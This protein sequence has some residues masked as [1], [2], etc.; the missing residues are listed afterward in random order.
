[1]KSISPQLLAFLE[2]T[3]SYNRA[4]LFLI[5]L[6]NGQVISATNCQT[7]VVYGYPPITYYPTLFGAWERG[8]YKT[9]VAFKPKAQK[10]KLTVVAKDTVLFP[11]ASSSPMLALPLMNVIQAGMFDGAKVSVFTIYWAIGGLPSD[12][13]AM[14]ALITF[15]GQI[16]ASTKTTRSIAEFDVADM[17]Y[18]LDYD[19][20]PNIIQSGCRY[21]LGDHGCTLNLPLNFSMPNSAAAGSNAF[22]INLTAS[23]T[24]AAFWNSFMTMTQ[25]EII[26]TS[27]LNNGLRYY[28]KQQISNTQ[29]QLAVPLKFAINTGDKF[30]LQPGCDKTLNKCQFQF[31]NLIHF[32]GQPYVPNPEAAI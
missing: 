30:N 2:T 31:N 21:K 10:M 20:P 23:V 9:E 19:T 18:L 3:N 32:G 28:I 8:S 25:G 7:A 29:I 16:A 4:D 13:V 6:I 11:V 15:V 26:F 22:Y 5:E 24:T 17:V 12:G 1:M 27:G 14:G